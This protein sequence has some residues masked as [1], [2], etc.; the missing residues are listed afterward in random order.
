MIR[1]LV[2]EIE[3]AEPPIGKVQ[4]DLLAKLP[5]ETNAIAV[6][7]ISIRIMSSGSIEGR[8]ISL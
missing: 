7:T 8:P 1:H 2:F 6:A 4:F 3:T 5:L